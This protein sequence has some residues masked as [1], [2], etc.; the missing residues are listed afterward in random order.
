M[1]RKLFL[2]F[3]NPFKLLIE[4]AKGRKPNKKKYN[5][6]GTLK[7]LIMY[8]FIGLSVV[9]FFV[10]LVGD[11]FMEEIFNPSFKSRESISIQAIPGTDNSYPDNPDG[12][13]NGLNT[14]LINSIPTNNYVKDLLTLYRDSSE[15]KINNYP[16]HLTLD[17]YIGIQVNETGTYNKVSLPKSYLPLV[18]NEVA[19]NKSVDGVSAEEMKVRNLSPSNALMFE[20]R[21]NGNGYNPSPS[22]YYGLFQNGDL[23][24]NGKEKSNLNYIGGSNNRGSHTFY[25]PD[26]ITYLDGR[27]TQTIDNFY[28]NDDGSVDDYI[29]TNKNGVNALIIVG[30][31][32]AGEG[33]FL[34]PLVQGKS[35]TM[36]GIGNSEDITKATVLLSKDLQ[37]GVDKHNSILT[38]PIGSGQSRSITAYLLCEQG[39]YLSEE[40]YSYLSKN[41]PGEDIVSLLMGEGKANSDLLNYFKSKIGKLDMSDSEAQNM[42]GWNSASSPWTFSEAYG[43][44][45][46][47]IF[48]HRKDT[49]VI[50]RTTGKPKDLVSVLQLEAGGQMFSAAYS[51]F[52]YYAYSLKMA[53]VDVDPTNPS[54]YFN[55]YEGEWVPEGGSGWLEDLGVDTS[56]LN[57]KRI[58]I[59]N[60]AYKFNGSYYVNTRPYVIPKKDSN[61]VWIND[62]IQGFDCSSLI[63]YVATTKLNLSVGTNTYQQI[64]NPNIEFIDRSEAKAGDLIFYYTAG[65]S[66]EHVS[67]FLSHTNSEYTQVVFHASQHG[68]PTG[69]SS[70]WN[71][72]TSYNNIKFARIKGIDS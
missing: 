20:S 36:S 32:N 61:G 37:A 49:K 4:L 16:T 64:V 12:S 70:N 41:P 30:S 2:L 46:G 11:N 34:T 9:S 67:L 25:L 62:G 23:S 38:V 19:Y 18:N 21:Y 44:P 14:M 66:C 63:D 35:H 33:G 15:G 48:K 7:N 13:L 24:N 53:G 29:K 10:I 57:P 39:W 28:T 60:E 43:Y 31:H 27:L 3:T 52:Y 65:G 56:K 8:P 71:Y 42:Y 6:K 5:S 22:G 47:F 54:T 68:I 59:L 40:G 26:N 50:D 72:K 69:V 51:G 45:K 58:G 55:K 1:I 17:N